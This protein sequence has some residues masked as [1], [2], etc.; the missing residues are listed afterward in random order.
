MSTT[1]FKRLNVSD[2]FVVPYT[3]NKSWDI[4]SSS[5]GDKRI[6]VNVGVKPS[7]SIFDPN[8]EYSTNG[9][10]DRLV[11]RSINLTY[12]PG[13]L[14]TTVN[15][16][17]NIYNTI[18]NNGTISTSSYYNGHVELGNKDTIK[19]FPTSSHSV[20]Y[21]LNVPKTI[22]SDKILPNTF[23]IY[24]SSGSNYTAKIY[25]DGN[26]NLFYSGSEI[27]SSI[28][29][30][31]NTGDYIGNVFYEQNI[32]VLTV[33]P[34]SIRLTGWRGKDY[35]CLPPSPSV[36]PTSTPS[37]TVSPS[38]TPT[39][40]PSITVTPSVTKT[41]LPTLSPT[42]T[43]SVTLSPTPTIS[44]TPTVTPSIT[45]SPSVPTVVLNLI[46]ENQ[47]N[48][49]TGYSP[50]AEMNGPYLTGGASFYIYDNTNYDFP[51]L[52][53]ESLYGTLLSNAY[54]T[55]GIVINVRMNNLSIGF[56]VYADF[57]L[58]RNGAQVDTKSILITNPTQQIFK[59]NTKFFTLGDTMTI[60]FLGET[61]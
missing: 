51:L 15:H 28:D 60:R 7:E 4:S 2:T 19:Y 24:F 47:V 9:Q 48:N 3:A 53:G 21:S 58:L 50:N 36:T 14:S 56:G 8:N 11:Y 16:N 52:H 32:A 5:F 45:V 31:L 37:N 26:Y 10:Y 34:N 17:S 23:E 38:V 18:Y 41:P 25:D 57:Q 35:T 30:L 59:F 46:V 1:S 54:N 33:V 27:L 29:T 6:T 55:S 42:R 43:P 61:T 39:V 20:V 40:T 49:V 44:V 13:F 22:T 12:Y